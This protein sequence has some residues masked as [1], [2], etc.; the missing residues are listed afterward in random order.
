MI[1][2][3]AVPGARASPSR[4]SSFFGDG[5][6]ARH[7]MPVTELDLEHVGAHDRSNRRRRLMT[8][9]GVCRQPSSSKR[10]LTD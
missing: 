6:Q 5:E 4:A 10:A 9:I 3:N 2:S 1:T 8:P 7:H